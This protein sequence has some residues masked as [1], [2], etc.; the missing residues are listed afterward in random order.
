MATQFDVIIIGGGPAGYVCAI[1]AA[2]LGLATAVVERDKLGGVCVNIG[3]IPTKALLHSAYVA[4]LVAHDAKDL[5][6]E[7]TGIKADYGVAMRRSRKVS[8]Q[9][10]KGVEFLMK[11]NKIKVYRGTGSFAAPKRIRVAGPDGEQEFSAS[12]VLIAT[13]SAVATLPGLDI[14]GDQIL[15]SDEVTTSAADPP[16]SLIVLG[17][18]AVGWSSPACTATSAPTSPS[19]RSWTGSCPPKTRRSPP[20]WPRP[21]TSAASG[22]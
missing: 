3:C 20:N 12:Y 19:S 14:D 17:S 1:R 6:V 11:K 7:V 2:Q 8:E 21:S 22:C 13:G 10:S 15:S 5:G 16:G 9:N 18:G 4:N